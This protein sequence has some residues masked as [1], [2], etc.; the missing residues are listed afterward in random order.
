MIES[1]II[2]GS[3]EVLFDVPATAAEFQA[4]RLGRRTLQMRKVVVIRLRGL[5]RPVHD[6]QE[7]FGLATRMAQVVL[8]PHF[9]PGQSRGA[10][11]AGA[12]VFQCALFHSSRTDLGGEL[13]PGSARRAH[14]Q[15]GNA[16][17]F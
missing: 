7:F 6:Q 5:G 4:Q 2:L 17:E 8:Q 10:A 14:R 15:P 16:G 12:A 11:L 1:Q 3:L 13:L 9:T